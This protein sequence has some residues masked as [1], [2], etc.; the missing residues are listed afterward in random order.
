MEVISGLTRWS[1]VVL[2]ANILAL[3]LCRTGEVSD[4]RMSRSSH[5]LD[6]RWIINDR[7]YANIIPSPG[8]II[9]GLVFELTASDERSLDNCE[10]STYK[11]LYIPVDLVP[12]NDAVNRRSVEALIYVDV[13]R[14]RES[15]PV[16]EY[17][18]RMN[19]GMRDALKEGI[20]DDYIKKYLRPFIPELA[21]N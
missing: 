5:S 2:T 1:A 11:K 20:S 7:G 13:E 6:R 19:M 21:E 4:Q 17:I 18:Y 10:S 14:K 3:L 8:D 12:K 16:E 15:K 9:Y